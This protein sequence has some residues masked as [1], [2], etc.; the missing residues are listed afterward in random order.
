MTGEGGLLAAVSAGKTNVRDPK[1]RASW[2][3]ERDRKPDESGPMNFGGFYSLA[4]RRHG[5]WKGESN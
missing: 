3:L 1:A 2:A 5:L 4:R